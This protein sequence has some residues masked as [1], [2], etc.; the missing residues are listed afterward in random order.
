MD[1]WA[2]GVLAYELLAERGALSKMPV[3][4]YWDALLG[5]APLPWEVDCGAVKV[6]KR[7][8]RVIRRMLSRVPA[9]RPCMAEVLFEWRAATSLGAE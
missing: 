3:H 2:L 9:T 5:H 7:F 1:V 6:G 4:V 8:G